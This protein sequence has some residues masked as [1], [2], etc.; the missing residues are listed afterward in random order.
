MT[1]GLIIFDCDGV[2]VDSEP[3]AIRVLLEA[4]E[5]Q[6]ITLDPAIAYRDYLGRSL[7]SISAS[8]HDSHGAPLGEA[9]LASMRHDLYALYRRELRATPG[10]EEALAQITIPICVASS[11]HLE[12]IRVSLEVTG[13]IDYFEPRIFSASMVENGKPAPDLFLHAARSMGV[14]PADCLVIEDSPA[15]IAA[16]RA[17]G[18]QVFAYAGGGHI[19]AGNVLPQIEA[20]GPDRI[21]TDMRQLPLM[22]A[23]SGSQPLLVAVDV[24]TGSA[25]SGVFTADGRMLGRAEQP[26]DLRWLDANHAEHSSEQIWASVCIAVRNAM[27]LAGADPARVA[28]ISFDATC[29]LVVRDR[30]GHP[31]AVSPEGDDHWDTI[32]WFDHRARGEAAECTATGHEV[33]SYIGGVM[34][35]EMQVPKLMWLRRHVPQTWDR[36]GYFFDLTDFLTWKATGALAR[37]QSTLVCKWTFLGHTAPGWRRDFLAEVGLDDLPE[38]GSLPE[39]ANPV[40]SSAG[41]LTREAADAL[42]LTEDCQVGIGLIDAHAGALGVLGRFAADHAD[43]HR[44]LGLVAGTSS[45]IM[46]LSADPRAMHG[47]WGPY[48]GAVMP[49]V[50]LN[51]A[52]QSAAGAVLDYVLRSHRAGGEPTAALHKAVTDRIAQLR[53]REGRNLAGRLHIV[54]DFHGN[55]S[56]LGDPDALGVISGLNLDTDFDSLCRLYWRAAVSI[57][58]GLRHILETLGEKGYVTDMLH[59]TGGHIHSPLL[60]ELYADVTGSVIQV[61]DCDAVLLGT[62]M[63]AATAAGL[64]PDLEAAGA[65]MSRD[66]RSH[67]PNPHARAR[68]DHDYRVFREM[69]RHRQALDALDR[70]RVAT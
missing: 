36:A 17:A 59:V 35:P 56:P 64:H 15:G 55:R 45:C 69:I 8:L 18:M 21:F 28:G 4:I 22:L 43:L 46:A 60:M 40:G 48:F 29:S 6:G 62:A 24:G 23:E 37:S 5:A 2:L 1:T 38:R 58:L 49:G 12:R 10:L 54:P 39:E 27:R 30:A 3:L 41:R 66:G 19:A 16:A 20:A 65:A 47:V 51:E 42:G 14:A 26:I 67:E 63:V 31:L 44:H 61:P 57:A 68:Y 11:S 25:R 7:A 52:G 32:C 34:S 70:E 13:L 53:E 33:L 50:W 9:A